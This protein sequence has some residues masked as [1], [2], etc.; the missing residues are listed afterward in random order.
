MCIIVHVL[1]SDFESQHCRYEADEQAL[2]TGCLLT[3]RLCTHAGKL[4]FSLTGGSSFH[5]SSI[6]WTPSQPGDMP[7]HMR[8]PQ[9]PGTHPQQHHGQHMEAQP[10]SNLNCAKHEQHEADAADAVG[11]GGAP[12]LRHPRSD[13]LLSQ[14]PDAERH[15]R[16]MAKVADMS[17]APADRAELAEALQQRACVAD[18]CKR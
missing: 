1:G 17:H 12:K 4:R 8:A 18:A 13:W 9:T 6:V 15:F 2:L 10:S 11:A 16:I 14:L 5:S 3:Y 7:V